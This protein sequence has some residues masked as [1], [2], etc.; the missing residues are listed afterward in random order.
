[1]DIAGNLTQ[2]SRWT[3]KG[4]HRQQSNIELYL[5]LTRKNV[6]ALSSR[7]LGRKFKLTFDN[8]CHKYDKLEKEYNA[9]IA[10][11]RVWANIMH[12][13]AADLTND[14]HFMK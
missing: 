13:L 9:G 14:S 6:N 7:T 3:L 1:M 8:F 2:I 12:T 11:H 4:F 5:K 10:D